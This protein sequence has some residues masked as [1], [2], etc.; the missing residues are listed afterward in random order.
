VMTAGLPRIASS[1]TAD[2]LA[3]ASRSWISRMINHHQI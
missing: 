3:F 2:R 1:T